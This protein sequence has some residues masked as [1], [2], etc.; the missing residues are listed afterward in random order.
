MTAAAAASGLWSGAGGAIGGGLISG[1]FGLLSSIGTNQTMASAKEAELKAQTF[2]IQQ[3]LE[4]AKWGI[5]SSLANQIGSNRWFYDIAGDLDLNRQKLAKNY[6]L[7]F[8]SPKQAAQDREFGRAELDFRNSPAYRQLQ[9]GPG[10][11]TA[12]NETAKSYAEKTAMFGKIA[13]PAFGSFR[14][15]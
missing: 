3:G 4:T 2:G 7:N 13:H 15:S 8:L 14:V 6:D 11:Q 12:L 10:K 1:A 9:E 5:N